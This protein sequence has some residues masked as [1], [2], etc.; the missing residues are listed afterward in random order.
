MW[1]CGLCE[2]VSLSSSGLVLIALLYLVSTVRKLG[3][4]VWVVPHTPHEQ[5]DAE[6]HGDRHGRP[7]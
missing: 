1:R 5:E 6:N 2:G 7:V 3:A 4:A